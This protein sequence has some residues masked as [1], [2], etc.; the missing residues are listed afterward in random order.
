MRE[1][2]V[3]DLSLRRCCSML[4]IS[5]VDKKSAKLCM[6][7][8]DAMLIADWMSWSFK[9]FIIVFSMSRFDWFRML[10]WSFGMLLANLSSKN[11][12]ICLTRRFSMTASGT[13]LKSFSRR[14]D[15]TLFQ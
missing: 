6:L 8:S 11:R 1:N 4:P 2:S 14:L 5:N 7:F 10:L 15:I 3:K 12:F 9:A 13:V